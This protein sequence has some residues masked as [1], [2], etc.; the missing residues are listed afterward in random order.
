[1]SYS[2]RWQELFGPP[3]ESGVGMTLASTAPEPVTRGESGAGNLKHSQGPWTSA[4]GTAGE[5][6]TGTETSRAALGPGHEGVA[7][8]GAGLAS[9]A[10]L[11]SVLTSWQERLKAVRDE[12]DALEGTLLSV[13]KEMGETETAIKNSFAGVSGKPEETR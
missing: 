11:T 7:D 8:G 12:C 13:A 9:V 10:S 3:V 6:R 1:M 4:S 5:L 2:E